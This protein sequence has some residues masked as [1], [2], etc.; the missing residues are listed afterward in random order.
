[1][2]TLCLNCARLSA[3]VCTRLISPKFTLQDASEIKY[4]EAKM[5]RLLPKICQI[6]TSILPPKP[7]FVSTAFSKQKENLFK[8][9]HDES[10]FFSPLQRSRLLWEALNRI[11]ST[12]PHHDQLSM[13]S[14]LANKTYLA[15]YPL[16]DGSCEDDVRP[17][18][19]HQT[20]RAALF[21]QWG[22][23]RKFYKLQPIDHIKNYFG[24]R[25]G[26]YFG[27]M[28]FYTLMLLPAAVVGLLCLLF[29]AFSMG[30]SVS[31]HEVCHSDSTVGDTVMCPI[32][33][34][35]CSFWRLRDGCV[36]TKLAYLMDN[37]STFAF[38]M[39]MAL[40]SSFFIVLWKRRQTLLSWS[41][42]TFDVTE[43]EEP[44]R[45]ELMRKIKPEKW[46][47]NPITG[48][49]EPYVPGGIRALYGFLSSVAVVFMVLLVLA[50]TTAL[51]VY[52][53]V[54]NV[55]IEA[56]ASP[57]GTGNFSSMI[58]SPAFQPFAVR[59]SGL[60]VAFSASILNLIVILALSNVYYFLAKWLTERG[61]CKIFH[62]T[63][64]VHKLCMV[65]LHAVEM[66][67]TQ[68]EYQDSL[69]FKY[70]AFDFVNSYTSLFYVAFFKGRVPPA[71][72]GAQGHLGLPVDR[73]QC[74]KGSCLLELTIQL[75]VLFLG[76][77]TVTFVKEIIYPSVLRYFRR[78]KRRRLSML[79]S[80]ETRWK[81]D[82]DLLPFPPM[83]LFKEYSRMVKQFGFITMFVA[84][85]PLAP[86]FA[87]ITN[88]IEIR[89]S[90]YKYL[91][92]YRR[93]IPLW[94][95]NI[96]AWDDILSNLSRVAIITNAF[97]IAFSTDLVPELVYLLAFSEDGSL[98]GYN[99]WRLSDFAVTDYA[100][101]AMPATVVSSFNSSELPDSC[102]Y[103]EFRTG[104]E[105]SIPYTLSTVFWHVL[106]A[107]LI[108]VIVLEHF[109]I[110][111]TKIVAVLLPEV[112]T[113]LRIKILRENY[114][115]RE[116]LYGSEETGRGNLC[117]SRSS[118]ENP[119]S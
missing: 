9:P 42:D 97:V 12:D 100:K 106:A 92:L 29:G 76:T 8:I 98:H 62:V 57:V 112:P 47:E 24:E 43:H 50:A 79:K 89:L 61:K 116:A 55:A 54:L 25:M 45:P 86:L 65:R 81:R 2:Y 52:R 34:K 7:H 105:E 88:L 69:T 6:D 78:E 5:A 27:W 71:L 4:V 16:H 22:R 39:F 64:S 87:L 73:V 17:T 118:S 68:T 41:F 19:D 56:S 31:V 77:T 70:F 102:W 113:A 51:V 1:M 30:S 91:T 96:G 82:N 83:G 104:P 75:M 114:R 35:R 67:R 11:Q 108:L 53:I 103:R 15:V 44:V 23:F 10:Q 38:A 80:V 115:A 37:P 74:V 117:T 107:R 20:S 99:N 93:P 95:R 60:I 109:I 85:F 101:S 59:N 49:R 18:K 119:L 48:I 21:D 46:R 32:C 90:A 84:A 3:N 111:L 28:E 58:S 26:F 33:N 63:R 94:S 66:P 72:P 40:W 36:N 110:V 14:L 13:G